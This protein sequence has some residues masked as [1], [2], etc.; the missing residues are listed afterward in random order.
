MRQSVPILPSH[1]AVADALRA[2]W[3]QR[4]FNGGWFDVHHVIHDR[5]TPELA[6][7]FDAALPGCRRLKSGWWAG[8]H[9]LNRVRALLETLCMEGLIERDRRPGDP[10][11]C[12]C[13]RF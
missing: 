10:P 3:N 5:E 7:A 4:R 9:R 11:F 13:Y 1:V 2:L 8:C 12:D 6:A